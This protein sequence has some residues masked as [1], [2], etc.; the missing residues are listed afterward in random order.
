M[1]SGHRLPAQDVAQLSGM[2][3]TTWHF[4]LCDQKEKIRERSKNKLIL[5][6]LEHNANVSVV[7]ICD[8]CLE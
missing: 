4:V 7:T 5:T 8:V 6:G 2:Y 1:Y 3:H